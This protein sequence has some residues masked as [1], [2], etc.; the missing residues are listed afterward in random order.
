[1]VDRSL[2]LKVVSLRPRW[3][4]PRLLATVF[5]GPFSLVCQL[6]AQTP[7]TAAYPAT[8]AA[9]AGMTS[10]IPGASDYEQAQMVR[11]R[12]AAQNAHGRAAAASIARSADQ[13][14]ENQRTQ[15]LLQS[16]REIKFLKRD[17]AERSKWE[18]SNQAQIN[19]V[20]SNDMSSWETTTGS[21]KVKRDVPDPFL[22]AMIELEGREKPPRKER[23]GF[24]GLNPF[25]KAEPDPV[26]AVQ[27]IN[28][29][30]PGLTTPALQLAP[31][32][33]P[34]RSAGTNAGLV[35]EGSRF[36]RGFRGIKIPKIGNKTP[37]PEKVA[38]SEEP[39][40]MGNSSIGPANTSEPSRL[41]RSLIDGSSNNVEVSISGQAPTEKRRLF[42]GFKKSE[43]QLTSALI[44][45]RA[46]VTAPSGSSGG[47]FFGFSK[48]KSD[49]TIDAGLFPDGAVDR[50]PNGRNLSGGYN[51]NVHAQDASFASSSTGEIV[52]PGESPKKRNRFNFSMPEI[53]F[54]SVSLANTKPVAGQDIGSVPTLTTINS[55]GT[56]Y[57]IV[58]STA[59]FMVYGDDQ[60]SSEVRALGS[61]TLV[62]MTKP[63][64]QW[65]S[66]QLPDGSEGV[67]Q[68]KFLRAASVAE[69][70]RQFLN[71]AGR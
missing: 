31:T 58:T 1:M 54:P 47:G 30:L 57:Y 16:A 13:A 62:R 71:P 14:L 55:E 39:Q 29:P 3:I 44:D 5:I 24:S 59:Q 69:S 36:F 65:A 18:R 60:M 68:N 9:S 64:E 41:G 51:A 6:E 40:F 11:I 48:N 28:D 52:M 61:G 17:I 42:S 21:V 67:V 56:E 66:I 7:S 49:N 50:A 22:T 12:T 32:G 27:V 37:E 8:P 35:G 33:S 63:G 23:K 45:P 19:K 46:S 70:G 38:F 26:A 34:S 20:S 43:P 10:G 25:K 15:R 4:F 2:L 53:S